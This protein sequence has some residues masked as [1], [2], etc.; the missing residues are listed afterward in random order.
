MLQF[1]TTLPYPPE[2]EQ[3]QLLPDRVE[4]LLEHRALARAGQLESEQLLDLADK[5]R[6]LGHRTVLVWDVL[7]TDREIA[8]AATVLADLNPRR[9]DAVRVQDPGIAWFLKQSEPDLPLQLVLET[10]N[11][12]LTGLEAWLQRFQP[13]RLIVSNE[14]PIGELSR[15]SRSLPVP[16]EVL[17]LGRILLFYTPRKLISPVE[18]ASAA[19]GWLERRV[20]SEEDRKNFPI[21]ESDHG[22]FMYYEKELFLLPWLDEIE[23]AGIAYARLDLKFHKQELLPLLGSF[24]AKREAPLLEP[25]KACL[26]SR[27]TRGF[28]KSNR[29]D[30]QFTRLKNPHLGSRED[31]PF[32]GQVLEARKREYIALSTQHPFAV[33]D[34]LYFAIPE[35]DMLEATVSWISDATGQRV[36]EASPPGLWLIN[37]R[38][39]VSSGTKVYTSNKV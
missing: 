14:I 15:M 1:T 24:L 22:T 21:V 27:L 34:T 4:V 11:H 25:I 33:G 17:V 35:G 31:R 18:P 39:R 6:A 23:A 29:T 38:G 37:H 20:V 16:M 5:A 26:S 9:F 32:L 12:N 30:K 13:E 10:G 19:G 2:P 28:F 7:A 3:L 8:A 36:T